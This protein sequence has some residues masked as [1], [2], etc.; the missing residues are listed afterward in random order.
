MHA[1]TKLS[2][3]IAVVISLSFGYL[4]QKQNEIL[5]IVLQDVEHLEVYCKQYIYIY[6][7]IYIYILYR[8]ISL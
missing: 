3:N 7:Y 2:I 8:C 1:F 6:M 5:Y 4:V